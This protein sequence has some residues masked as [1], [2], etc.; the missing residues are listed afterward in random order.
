L[1]VDKHH[2]GKQILA[3]RLRGLSSKAMAQAV[4]AKDA[5][6]E[7]RRLCALTTAWE[8]YAREEHLKFLNTV[9]EDQCEMYANAASEPLDTT[10]E[11]LL[12]CSEGELKDNISCGVA[13]YSHDVM[14]F[15]VG[16]AQYNHL[17]SAATRTYFHSSSDIITDDYLYKLLVWTTRMLRRV[18][19]QGTTIAEVIIIIDP[20]MIKLV[21][22]QHHS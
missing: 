2:Q 17:E 21:L 16:D 15:S 19:I 9:L 6:V 18:K 8:V 11:E 13:A 22:T 10:I 14:A 20:V 1:L 12:A 5:D 3:R 7:W 4:A